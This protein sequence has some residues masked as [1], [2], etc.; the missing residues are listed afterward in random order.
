MDQFGP[1]LDAQLEAAISELRLIDVQL[2]LLEFARNI[3]WAKIFHAFNEG[4]Y[5][6]QPARYETADGWEAVRGMTESE[7][8]LS[9]E[10]LRAEMQRLLTPEEFKK[11]WTRVTTAKR[12]V[13]LEK[14]HNAVAKGALPRTLL[15]VAVRHTARI[16]TRKLNQPKSEEGAGF[17]LDPLLV[18]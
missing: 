3:A 17:Y 11:A 18:I 8:R 14:L 7:L 13:S 10:A 16:Y 2:E 5:E 1:E 9:E 15:D 6:G 12:E 4:G